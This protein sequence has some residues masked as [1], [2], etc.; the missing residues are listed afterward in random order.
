MRISNEKKRHPEF[1]K[2]KLQLAKYLL[3][4]NNNILRLQAVLINSPKP[5]Q[6][7]FFDFLNEV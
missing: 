7:Y 1:G 4:N 3:N 2:V 5:V 6:V